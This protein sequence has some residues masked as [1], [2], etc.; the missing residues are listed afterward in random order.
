MAVV[1]GWKMD[2][3]MGLGEGCCGHALNAYVHQSACYQSA[4]SN[5]RALRGMLSTGG[6]RG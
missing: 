3:L 4:H 5:A 2:P 1:S 6:G